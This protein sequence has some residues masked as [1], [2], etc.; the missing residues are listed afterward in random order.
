MTTMT[1]KDTKKVGGINDTNILIQGKGKRQNCLAMQYSWFG[2]DV[3]QKQ[4]GK[5]G[6]MLSGAS[7][8]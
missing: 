5:K 2:D 8:S 3:E 4:L 7:C 6:Q 1:I